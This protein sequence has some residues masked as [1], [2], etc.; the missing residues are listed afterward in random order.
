MPTRQLRRSR[1]FIDSEGNS[2]ATDSSGAANS[3]V[4]L[5]KVIQPLTVPINLNAEQQ[6]FTPSF[7]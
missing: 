2:K 6:D 3:Q 1:M 4:E 5:G 7:W